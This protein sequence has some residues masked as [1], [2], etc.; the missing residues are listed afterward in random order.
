M[1]SVPLQYPSEWP[2]V[3][4]RS[5]L[6]GMPR[7][8][9][10]A[11]VYRDLCDQLA[12]RTADCWVQWGGSGPRLDLARSL[13]RALGDAADWPNAIFLPVDPFVLAAWDHDSCAIDDLAVLSAL[14]DQAAHFGLLK[15]SVNWS[16]FE[17]SS[18]GEVVDQLLRQ[19]T[20]L[21]A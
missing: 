15:G 5:F 21:G 17:S 11:S 6:L 9:A 8:G 20:K 4:G 2:K 13:A 12:V 18:F 16:Q 19:G 10:Q 7:V 14:D 3:V 1:A